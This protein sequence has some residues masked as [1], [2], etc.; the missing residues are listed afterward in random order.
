MT[1]MAAGC[2]H[3]EVRLVT[4][5]DRLLDMSTSVLAS[6]AVYVALNSSS[7]RV[8]SV[9]GGVLLV[10]TSCTQDLMRSS[11]QLDELEPRGSDVCSLSLHAFSMVTEECVL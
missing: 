6:Q 3:Y 1:V 4:L 7:S 8:I 10:S 11:L 9:F 5:G 2:Y